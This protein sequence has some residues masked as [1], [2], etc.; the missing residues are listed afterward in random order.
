MLHVEEEGRS[1]Y[2][3]VGPFFSVRGVVSS[4]LR[5]AAFPLRYVGVLSATLRGVGGRSRGVFSSSSWT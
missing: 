4:T 2:Y 1:D 3:G 5:G